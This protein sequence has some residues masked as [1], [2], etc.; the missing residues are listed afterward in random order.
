MQVY[1]SDA[2]GELFDQTIKVTGKAGWKRQWWRSFLLDA[3]VI[4]PF[5]I[6]PC[7]ERYGLVAN[8][9]ELFTVTHLPTGRAIYRFRTLRGAIGFVNAVR[10]M[11]WHGLDVPGDCMETCKYQ[12]SYESAS[13][14]LPDIDDV[15]SAAHLWRDKEKSNDDPQAIAC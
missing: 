5:A 3:A 11:D 12:F 1:S 7:I 6:H 9:K 10:G 15:I 8:P 4:E 14:L 2:M 13:E